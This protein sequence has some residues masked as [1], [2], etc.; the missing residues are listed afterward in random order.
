MGSMKP[1]LGK[2]QEETEKNIGDAQFLDDL[3]KQNYNAAEQER[4]ERIELE[5]AMAEI[6]EDL[7][8]NPVSRR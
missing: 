3:F 1:S 2:L 8:D 6:K 5:K 7:D 4:K